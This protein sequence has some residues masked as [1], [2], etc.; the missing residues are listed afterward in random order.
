[1]KLILWEFYSLIS[2]SWMLVVIIPLGIACAGGA[3]PGMLELRR[4]RSLEGALP[5]LLE[6]MS[7]TLGAGLGLEQALHDVAR[8]RNDITGTLMTEAMSRTKATSFETALAEY[9]LKSRSVIIQRVMN[10]L[11]VAIEQN[12][13]LQE[14]TN[15]MSIEYDRLNKLMN[16]RESEMMGQTFLLLMLMGFLLPAIMGFTFAAFVPPSTGIYVGDLNGAM[17]PY[18]MG[19]TGISLAVGGRMLGRMVQMLWW[20]PLAMSVSAL[21]YLQTYA[22]IGATIGG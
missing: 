4:R 12:A 14:V 21:V 2:T 6:A 5:E 3:I 9:A 19:A 8:A 7:N 13:P 17:V 10:L 20:A 22:F 15:S 11:M 16:Q 1:M 18:L